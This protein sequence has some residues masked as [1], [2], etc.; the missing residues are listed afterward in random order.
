M[1]ENGPRNWSWFIKSLGSPGSS[2]CKESACNSGD[3][4]S[5][6]E[7]GRS[8]GEGNGYPLQ[9][10]YL[11]NSMDRGAGQAIVY[12]VTKSLTQLSDE[13]SKEPRMPY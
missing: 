10:S 2:D 4:G 5:I 13:H 1:Q 11:E 9:H 3:P 8:P 7:S 6:P 12:G